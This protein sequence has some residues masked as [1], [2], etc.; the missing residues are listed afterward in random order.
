ME[1]GVNVSEVEGEVSVHGCSWAACLPFLGFLPPGHHLVNN[2]LGET[3]EVSNACSSTS[4]AA[5]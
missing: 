2:I 3:P 4:Q 1:H 5:P